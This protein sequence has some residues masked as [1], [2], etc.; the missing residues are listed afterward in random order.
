MEA[1]NLYANEVLSDSQEDAP[2][3]EEVQRVL[4]EI[5]SNSPC[6]RSSLGVKRKLPEEKEYE[7]VACEVARLEKRRGKRVLLVSNENVTDGIKIK[8]EAK[9]KIPNVKT[10]TDSTKLFSIEQISLPDSC[11][12]FNTVVLSWHLKTTLKFA[13]L[14]SSHFS[15]VS[16]GAKKTKNGIWLKWNLNPTDQATIGR[17]I[18][19]LIELYERNLNNS[20]Q[21]DQLVSFCNGK[22]G[23]K[24]QDI[25]SLQEKKLPASE[26][27]SFEAIIA[28]NEQCAHR[29]D[30]E[31]GSPNTRFYFRLQLCE[32]IQEEA[33]K[34]MGLALAESSLIKVVAP[35]KSKQPVAP[36]SKSSKKGVKSSS[37]MTVKQMMETFLLT[38]Q[39][40][41]ERLS[42]LEQRME[43][44]A[45]SIK[46]EVK[47]E[48]LPDGGSI[49]YPS[50]HQDCKSEQHHTTLRHSCEFN[51]SQEEGFLTL[52]QEMSL[53]MPD[54]SLLGP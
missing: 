30:N 22:C 49:E 11:S 6:L 27:A 2:S 19:L 7:P 40:F 50:L 29:S 14:S 12:L 41:D 25:I 4:A 3:P 28:I 15:F 1:D 54:H 52:S 24:K 51:F 34:L 47:V 43:D 45:T 32:K 5:E 46:E 8:Q 23:Q 44:R 37:K 21:P 36:T 42:K 17:E 10:A 38:M 9:E 31:Y 26:N 13:D 18:Y 35:G 20:Q 39:S 53:M 48:E 33:T 16:Q